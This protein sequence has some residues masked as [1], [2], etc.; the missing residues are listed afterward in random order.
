MRNGITGARP[1]TLAMRG[2][3]VQT[4]GNRVTVELVDGRVTWWLDHVPTD[5][6]KGDNG[7]RKSL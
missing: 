1:M 2:N 7:D 4:R 3:D 5:D 6:E